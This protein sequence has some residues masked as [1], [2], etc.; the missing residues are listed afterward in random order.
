MVLENVLISFFYI[1]CLV[2]LFNVSCPH[3]LSVTVANRKGQIQGLTL[4]EA[5]PA[6]P[7]FPLHLKFPLP[8]A[9]PM[10]PTLQMSV[11]GLP[12][13][14]G[15]FRSFFCWD[16]AICP[17]VMWKTP[18]QTSPPTQ[19]QAPRWSASPLYPKWFQLP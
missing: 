13:P 6:V 11:E 10:S 17:P 1:V 2:L 4:T 16:Q 18:V 12:P 7:F 3:W 14:P 5:D 15:G 8:R 9:P 19:E